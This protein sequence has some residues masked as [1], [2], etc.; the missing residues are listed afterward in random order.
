VPS[1]RSAVLEAVEQLRHAQGG[2]LAYREMRW[3]G[4][5]FLFL[6]ITTTAGKAEGG[7]KPLTVRQ[8]VS[9]KA[10]SAM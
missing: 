7:K 2:I 3:A 4:I 10:G 5:S 1:L 8:V 9:E 6:E